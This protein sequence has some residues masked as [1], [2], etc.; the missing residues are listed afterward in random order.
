MAKLCR[1]LCALLLGWIC[2]HAAAG[3]I[4]DYSYDPYNLPP[5]QRPSYWIERKV[6]ATGEEAQ[7]ACNEAA[8]GRTFI[9]SLRPGECQPSSSGIAGDDGTLVWRGGWWVCS[10]PCSYKPEY[11]LMFF[12]HLACAPG[13]AFNPPASAAVP[14]GHVFCLR[15]PAPPEPA[16]CRADGI[17]AGHLNRGA[18][19][20]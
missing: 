14:D 19:C 1:A 17:I 15:H 18:L 3:Q 4:A 10:G 12:Y 16:M 8:A 7:R 2:S 5:G 9:A 11:S 20:R 6:W 13:Y